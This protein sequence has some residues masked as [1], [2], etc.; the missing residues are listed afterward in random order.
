[1]LTGLAEGEVD[2]Q[3]H[4]G[5]I[6]GELQRSRTIRLQ[7]RLTEATLDE[8]ATR[9]AESAPTNGWSLWGSADGPPKLSRVVRPHSR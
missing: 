9:L 6:A 2:D 5:V 4:G 3:H 8:R 1:M 7:G